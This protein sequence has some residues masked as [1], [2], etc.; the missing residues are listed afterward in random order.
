MNIKK[1]IIEDEDSKQIEF[2]IKDGC[3]IFIT[4]NNQ[5]IILP[6][7]DD[8]IKFNLMKYILK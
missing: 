4:S 8:S 5:T 3:G 7:N 6:T 1:I 2:D